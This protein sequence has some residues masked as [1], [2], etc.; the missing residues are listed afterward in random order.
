MIH[1]ICGNPGGG[2]SF[3]AVRQILFE[4]QHTRRKIVTNLELRFENLQAYLSEQDWWQDGHVMSRI[5]HLPEASAKEFYRYRSNDPVPLVKKE[6]LDY[7]VP[8]F[9]RSAPEGVL[10]VIDEVHTLFSSREWFKTGQVVI[11]YQTQHRKLGDDVILI[12]Q[13]PEQVDKAFRRLAQDWSYLRNLGQEKT[14]GFTAKGW[15]RR[16]CYLR[17]K[18]PGDGQHP[19]ETGFIALDIS[20]IGQLYDTNAGVGIS[21]R[22][23]A[24]KES[25]VRGLPYW[26]APLIGIGLLVLAYF[27]IRGAV[28][29]FKAGVRHVVGAG[30]AVAAA[31]MPG[32]VSNAAPVE[33]HQVDRPRRELNS[34]LMIG[35][36]AR[37]FF[38]DG[39][40]VD[41]G[42]P[43]FL[44]GGEDWVRLS[45]GLYRK[46]KLAVP[47]PVMEPSFFSA[48]REQNHQVPR[49]VFPE[50][51]GKPPVP[52]KTAVEV[53]RE[54][55]PVSR[56][57]TD[58]SQNKT[59]P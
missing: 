24:K 31:V 42:E 50:R 37:Y 46:R 13:H 2:K 17:V 41:A 29:G 16:S 7:E 38:S 22:G 15:L 21:G 8:D 58:M 44:A 12:S 23:D 53:L 48:D 32:A 51:P 28:S 1:F 10:Y 40:V 19:Q 18:T 14:L 45:D 33:V 49:W 54:H 5:V 30:D 52:E 11:W 3:Y 9:S 26:S 34:V 57:E 4:L 55:Y 25:K 39:S 56:N 43:G 6:G 47:L 59:L 27:A 36:K 35:T 20:G